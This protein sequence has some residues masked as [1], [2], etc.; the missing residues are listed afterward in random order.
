MIWSE[1][2]PLGG[3]VCMQILIMH[4]IE[5]ASGQHGGM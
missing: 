1:H 2:I 4:V 3:V 5:V